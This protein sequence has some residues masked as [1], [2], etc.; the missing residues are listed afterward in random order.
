VLVWEEVSISLEKKKASN[1]AL[2]MN[3]KSF[4]FSL[5]SKNKSLGKFLISKISI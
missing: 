3:E 4:D 1:S 2:P 5:D